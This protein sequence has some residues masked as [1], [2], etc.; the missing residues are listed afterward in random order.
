MHPMNVLVTASAHF[1]QTPDGTL[2][3]KD[4]SLGY[5]FWAPYLEVYDTLLACVRT[6]QCG[7]PPEGWVQSSGERM[8][9]IAMP[10][11]YGPRGMARHYLALRQTTQAALAQADAVQM[12]ISCPI[13]GTVFA[14]L[15]LGRPYGVEVVNDPY[16]VF[17]PGSVKHPLRP[18]FRWWFPHEL[19]QQ[20]ASAAGA[21]YVTQHALQRRYPCPNYM[22]GVS[23]VDISGDALVRQPRPPRPEQQRFTL[24]FVGSLAQLYKAPNILIAA[25][26]QCIHEGLD[27]RLVMIGDGYYRKELAAQ[28]AEAGI[29][30]QVQFLGQ[31]PTKDDVRKWLDHA[32]L[33]VLPSYQEGLPRAMVEAMARAL[34]CIGSTVGGIPELL[35]A[36]DLVPPGDVNALARKI[37]EIATDPQRMARMSVRNLTTALDYHTTKL[38][39]RRKAFYEHIRERT[40]H[41][42]QQQARAA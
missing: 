25:M 12:R 28:A 30:E 37:C 7:H 26:A 33:F 6:R 14:Q 20:C 1:A 39:A 18:F 24:V 31:L 27:L 4:A 9:V 17:A 3:A 22:V 16:D 15:P 38:A 13:G 34:P 42:L 2:W 23:D 41:W 40:E 10:D 8:T 35:A 29:A 32:D 36:E 21:L 19:R 5:E 11:F